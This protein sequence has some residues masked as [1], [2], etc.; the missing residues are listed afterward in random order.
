MY[1]TS[2]PFR[3]PRRCAHI[4]SLSNKSASFASPSK[5]HQ[6]KRCSIKNPKLPLLLRQRSSCIALL[7]S[8]APDQRSIKRFK[9]EF[10]QTNQ[11]DVTNCLRKQNAIFETLKIARCLFYFICKI[12]NAECLNNQLI[13]FVKLIVN[14]NTL[15]TSLLIK[16]KNCF[17]RSTFSTH[18]RIGIRIK[19]K[20]FL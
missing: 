12:R 4:S 5:R 9:S 20:M 2:P 13:K 3:A 11:K 15:K 14:F 18:V 17:T 19:Q 7:A 1:N 8:I 6:T 10:V 16:N